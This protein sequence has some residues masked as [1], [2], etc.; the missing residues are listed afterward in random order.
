MQKKL[1]F[2]LWLLI[3]L[4]LMTVGSGSAFATEWEKAT[5]IAVGDVVLL[6][7]DNGTVTKELTGIS[8][9]STKYGMVEDYTDTPAGTYP[10]T[11]VAG[12]A[13][14][15]FAFQTP[16]TDYLYWYSGNSLSTSLS[17][18]DDSSWTVS[19]DGTTATITNVRARSGAGQRGG[20]AGGGRSSRRAA[21]GG[22][23]LDLRPP[24][25]AAGGCA[26]LRAPRAGG[27]HPHAEF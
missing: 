10:L 9:T 6:T 17:I 26:R 1:R 23:Q 2:N 5:S 15:S 19:F 22:H 21:G 24:A 25:V 4:M 7:V 3:G 8:T 18:G 16:E 14:G 27:R 12:S 11:V 20:G 13:E